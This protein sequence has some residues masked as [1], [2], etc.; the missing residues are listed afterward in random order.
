MRR[1][2][3]SLALI[4]ALLLTAC[5]VSVNDTSVTIVRGS[6]V[7]TSEARQ[8]SNFN[9]LSFTG[10]GE[11]TI[12]QGQTEALTIEAEDNII[13]QIKTEVRNGTL[14]IGFNRTKWQDQVTPTKPIKFILSVK[15]L[16]SVEST[17]LGNI[18]IGS[19]K[20]N[21]LN[22]KIAGAGN[23][24]VSNIETSSVTA[25]IAGTGSITLTGKATQLNSTLSG[26]GSVQAGDLATQ[27]ASI[28]VSGAGSA[29]VWTTETLNVTLSGAGSVNYYGNASVKKNITGVGM[30]KSLGAK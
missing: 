26:V 12:T 6:G 2:M 16:S 5:T 22:L 9:A 21:K 11:I 3:V 25:N 20:T 18:Q 28:T 27:Q 17:G 23:I 7:V 15:D 19:L 10:L 29:T 1:I 14:T 24:K 4:T 13:P 8:V 30:V